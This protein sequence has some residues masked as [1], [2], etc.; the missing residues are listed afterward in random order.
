MIVDTFIPIIVSFFII[1][2]TITATSMIIER[3]LPLPRLLTNHFD[4]QNH[5]PTLFGQLTIDIIIAFTTHH[6]SPPLSQSSNYL[7]MLHP[8]LSLSLSV[9]TVRALQLRYCASPSYLNPH[10]HFTVSQTSGA[11]FKNLGYM[12][13][14]VCDIIRCS[15]ILIPTISL[16]KSEAYFIAMILPTSVTLKT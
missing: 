9:P 7:P 2:P 10:H 15:N 16:I 3:F 11:Y 4:Y 13:C 6:Q 14:A 5:Y 12:T 8:P 1:N